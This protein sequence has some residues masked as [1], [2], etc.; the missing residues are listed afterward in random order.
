MTRS[1][2]CTVWRV[3]QACSSPGFDDDGVAAFVEAA[4]GVPIDAVPERAVRLLSEQTD[5]NP[6]LLGEL[7]RH[8]VET[9][10]L[11]CD[12][13]HWIAGPELEGL[14]S[15]ESVRSVVARRIDRLPG[16]ARASCSR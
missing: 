12:D 1:R 5:G 15:P 9:G 16:D 11:R 7:W 6:F 10:A 4:A 13:L 3:S 14:S 8:L 2:S